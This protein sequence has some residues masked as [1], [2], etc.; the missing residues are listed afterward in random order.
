M[1]RPVLIVCE[2]EKTEAIYFQ[3]LRRYYR[4]RTVDVTVHAEGGGPLEVVRRAIA[5]FE[6]RKRSWKR[7][8]AEPPYEEIWCVF[9][10]EA[11]NEPHGFRDALQLA[12]NHK[13][14]LAISNPSFEYWYLLHFVETSRPFQDAR[15]VERELCS[16]H[17][18]PNYQKNK[19][20]FAVLRDRTNEAHDRAERLYVRHPDRESDPYPNPSTLVYQLVAGMIIMASY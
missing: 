6:E 12:A 13:I 9:D 10:R 3:A 4:L 15:D 20:Y 19:D 16:A 1:R 5:L 17:Y 7:T 14:Q 11:S 8:R 2:G 18:I